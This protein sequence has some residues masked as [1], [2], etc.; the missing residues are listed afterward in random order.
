MLGFKIRIRQLSVHL[1]IGSGHG[2]SDSRQH[3]VC[4]D[5][6]DVVLVNLGA[7]HDSVVLL[8]ILFPSLACPLL[9]YRFGPPS[10]FLVLLEFL[11]RHVRVDRTCV[12]AVDAHGATARAGWGR[13]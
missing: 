6:I 9:A 7:H 3:V 5:P 4:G 10:S 11:V 1:G 8:V 12:A 13:G 2:K